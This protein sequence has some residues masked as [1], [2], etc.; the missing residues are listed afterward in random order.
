MWW[1]RPAAF[2]GDAEEEF[3][4]VTNLDN[5]GKILVNDPNYT[6]SIISYRGIAAPNIIGI[7]QSGSNVVL[8]WAFGTPPFQVQSTTNL[9]N[10]VWSNVGSTTTNSSVSV[11]IQS[12]AQFFRV[13][14]Q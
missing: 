2:T 8:N 3:F 10:P 9:S 11:P 4:S 13:F 6:N 12:G 1:C 14:G 7:L 5:G